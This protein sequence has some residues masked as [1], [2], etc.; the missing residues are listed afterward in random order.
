MYL[1]MINWEL[2]ILT[3]HGPGSNA[4]EE[5]FQNWTKSYLVAIQQASQSIPEN[6]SAS[7]YSGVSTAQCDFMPSCEQRNLIKNNYNSDFGKVRESRI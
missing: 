7:S 4:T 6:E 3:I 5:N 2:V 1:Y